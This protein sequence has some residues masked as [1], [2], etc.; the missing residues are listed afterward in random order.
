[1]VAN[2]RERK[3]RLLIAE[4]GQ[5]H[6]GDI[7]LAKELI[8]AAKDS[9]AD[10]AKFQYY[11]AKKLF[12]KHNNPWYEY[13]LATE[14]KK[15]DVFELSEL[16]KNLDIEFMCT[17]FDVH[18]IKDLEEVNVKRYKIA[19]RSI[20]DS[21]LIRSVIKTNKEIIASLGYWESPYFPDYFP[22]ERT[23]FLYCISKYPAQLSELKFQHNMFLRYDGFSDHSEGVNAVF[24]ALALGAKIIEKHFTLDKKMYGPDHL[25]SATP[26]E[27]LEIRKFMNDLSEIY[28]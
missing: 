12:S 10:I 21:D 24:V 19:S 16:C 13:N 23:R 25:C 3:V 2:S 28:A 6:N 11:D 20:H 5:N 17:G 15:D 4:I 26:D 18:K 22:R 27:F 9:G 14:L 7:K 8:H 1:M